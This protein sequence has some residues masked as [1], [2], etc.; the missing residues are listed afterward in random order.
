MRYLYLV[1][2]LAGLLPRWLPLL[3]QAPTFAL[4]RQLDSIATQ[5]VPPGAPGMA[6]AI[7]HHG[8][9]YYQ[10][11][12]GF[13]QL[14]D[15]QLIT[16]DSRFNIAS[17]AKQY[18]ALAV[19]LLVNEGRLRLEDD[20]RQ[21]FPAL[22]PAIRQRISIGH[23]LQHRSG[24]RDVYDLWSLQQITW[25]QQSYT[26][27][28]ALA[29]LQRQ[30]ALNFEPGSRYLYSNSN[31]I[32]LALLVEKLRGQPFAA[33]MQGLF[34]QLGMPATR[35]E[36]GATPLAGPIAAAYF[37]FNTWTTYR[38]QWRVVGD[39]NLFS[40][41]NDQIRWEQLLAGRGHTMVPLAVW[42]QLQ[43]FPDTPATQPYG[44]GLERGLYKGLPCVFHE[45]ATGAWKATVLRFPQEGWVFLTLVNTGKAI[46]AMQTRQLADAVL[47]LPA[48]IAE[49][50]PTVPNGQQLQ[51]AELEGVYLTPDYFRF[52]FVPENDQ[53][54]LHRNGRSDVVLQ[55]RDG[56]TWQQVG[57]SSFQLSFRRQA[58][59]Q[60]TVTAHHPSHAP[61]T[62]SRVQANWSGFDASQLSGSFY[63][64]ELDLTLQLQPVQGREYRLLI[65]ADTNR[66][67][68]VSPRLLLGGGYAIELPANQPGTLLL[69]GSRILG[70][71]FRRRY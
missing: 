14:P 62:L 45:G 29:L 24:L 64:E 66:A 50:Q 34:G 40:S 67:T 52:Q 5:D 9:L 13:A 19:L 10:R 2:L 33:Y 53:L 57:D 1:L 35:F 4:R 46:P 27:A 48:S 36:D 54:R 8:R 6:T 30:Q 31:Y 43:S 44:F 59:E 49:A 55:R 26:N 70:V 23:L 69:Q 11:V 16:P 38:W 61:Y 68:L 37:N 32:L 41:L 65:G 25:W 71:Q 3:A 15:S 20:I 58:D 17:N 7:L 28:D 63:N 60:Y 51:A 42:R 56:N 12:A 39:G 47:G 22:L 21:Y 18:T